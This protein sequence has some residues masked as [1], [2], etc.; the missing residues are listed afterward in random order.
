MTTMAEEEP[1]IPETM[2]LQRM[3]QQPAILGSMDDWT[4]INNAV[5]RR[6][7]QNRLNQRAHSGYPL[8]TRPDAV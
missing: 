5:D 4:G 8:S 7:V 3:P 1:T 6:K 2:A